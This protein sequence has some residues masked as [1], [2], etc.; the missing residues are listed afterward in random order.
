MQLSHKDEEY[1]H[2]SGLYDKIMKELGS[3]EELVSSLNLQLSNLGRSESSKS[4][5]Q[6]VQL[7]Q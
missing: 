3:K 2:L 4:E 6:I 1:Q 5:D 7:K